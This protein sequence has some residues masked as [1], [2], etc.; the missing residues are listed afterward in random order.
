M[1]MY[2]LFFQFFLAHW[3]RSFKR[4]QSLMKLELLYNKL[5]IFELEWTSFLSNISISLN[6]IDPGLNSQSSQS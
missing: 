4:Y 3:L 1:T 2:G 6:L 5:K